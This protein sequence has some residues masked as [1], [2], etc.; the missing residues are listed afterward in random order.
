ME[1]KNSEEV[2]WSE[3][4]ADGKTGWDIGYPSPALIEYA[5]NNI[6]KDAKVL[7]PGAGN[8]YEVETLFKEGWKGIHAL[9][10]SAHPLL[11]LKERCHEIPSDQLIQ[12]DFFEYEGKFDYIIEQT[13]FCSFLPDM[14]KAYIQK[15][16]DLLVSKGRLAGLLFDIPLDL[17]GR[18]FGGTE[19]EYR[20]LFQMKFEVVS[21]QPATNSIPPRM[22]NELFFEA[23]AI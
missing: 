6:P 17:K 7:I 2:Y 10:I 1:Q 16:H 19:K 9:D 3:R 18:P 4:W 15:M 5:R 14:R 8:G 13:F 23:R 20:E 22:G 21:M 12:A 11:Q